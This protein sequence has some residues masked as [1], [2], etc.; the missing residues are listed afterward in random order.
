MTTI[1]VSRGHPVLLLKS[2]KIAHQAGYYLLNGR[3]HAV[4]EHKQPPA[5]APVVQNKPS[6]GE[7][8]MTA[9]MW[10]QLYEHADNSN[11]ATY[12]KKLDKLKEAYKA[13]DTKTILSGSYPNDTTG[14]KVAKIANYLLGLMGS[15]HTVHPGLKQGTH[16]ALSDPHPTPKP[17]AAPAPQAAEPKPAPT[18]E[19][20]A[21]PAPAAEPEPAKT[22][23]GTV[24]QAMWDELYSHPD[25]SNKSV[26]T[27]K[28]DKLKAAYEAGDVNAILGGSY[29]NDTTNKKVVK[30]ANFLLGEMGS[31]HQVAAGQKQGTHAALGASTPAPVG[32]PPQAVDAAKVDAAPEAAPEATGQQPDAMA[33]PTFVEGKT[34]TGVVAYYEGVAQQIIA[35]GAAGDVAG[36]T[37]MKEAGLTPSAKGKVSNTFKGKTANSKLLLQLHAASLQQAGAVKG[38]VSTPETAHDK[39][40]G[41]A[42]LTG[43]F[44]KKADVDAALNSGDSQ[45]LAQIVDESEGAPPDTNL[46]K[47]HAYAKQ[48][49][50]YLGGQHQGEDGPKDGDTKQGADGT[51]VFKNGRWHKMVA[52]DE[53]GEMPPTLVPVEDHPAKPDLSEKD[54]AAKISAY[55]LSGPEG[56]DHAEGQELFE[57]LT[58]E[59]QH[60]LTLAAIQHQASEAGKAN[61]VHPVDAVPVPDMS[62]KYDSHKSKVDAAL[63]KLKEQVKAEGASALKGVTKTMSASGK[64]ITKL[65]GQFGSFKV[66]GYEHSPDLSGSKVHAYVEALKAAVGPAKKAPKAKA[67]PATVAPQPP[68]HNAIPAMDDWKQVGGQAGSNPGGKF[69]DGD[70]VEWYC[71]FPGNDDVAKSEVLAAKLYQAAGIAGQDAMLVTKDGKL[72]IA[73]KW[74]DVKKAATPTALAKVDGVASGFAVDAWLGNWDVVGLE[75]DNLQVDAATGKAMRVDAGGS[76]EYRAQGGKK[77]F[78][79]SVLEID[80]LRD[81]KINPQSAKVFGKLTDADITASV[82]KVLKVSDAQIHAMVNTYGPGSAADKKKLA[83]T[84]IA[85]KADLLSKYPKAK[86]EKKPTFKPEN[87]SAPPSFMNWGGSGNDGP[88]SKKFLNEANEKAVQSIY[89]AAKTG[90]VDAVTGLSADTFNKNTGEVI[91]SAPV[92]EHPSQHVKGYAQQAINEINYQLNP[93]KRFRFDGGH[94][95]ASLNAAYPSHTGPHG[96]TVEKAGK[97]L[98]LGEPGTISLESLALPKVTHASGQLTKATYSPAAQAAVKAMPETQKQ[99]IKQYTGSSYQKMNTSLWTGN[100][101]GAAKAAGEALHTMGHDITAGTVLSRK[102][103]VSGEALD[104]I[105]KSTGKVLQEP[106]IMSTSIR[107]TSWS[108]NVQ[109]KLNVGPGVKGLWVGPGSAP[110]GGGLSVHAH[111]DEI[112]LPPN[113]RLLVLSVKKSTGADADGFGAGVQHVIEAVVLPTHQAH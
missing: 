51:L 66:I 9:E 96:A 26:F 94:P 19:P 12:T 25:N 71:K 65:P 33:M 40:Q 29:P 56:G 54:K 76:L 100:P 46:G 103:S 36:L 38:S 112:I 45:A 18:P 55:L 69:V 101:T 91:G 110:G 73:S 50:E 108:G 6:G 70:G 62:W 1:L 48:A 44:A 53:H 34:T 81:A 27:K 83:E 102:I 74:Q 84:L 11:K 97:F 92:L 77:S 86:K 5:G 87:I 89:E 95:L 42:D 59:K 20:K 47:V 106:A 75:Y 17:A 68:G 105:L 78:G 80:S 2:K 99:A 98:I 22:A 107:P 72:G 35:M 79:A 24:T 16:H 32:E 30:I 90:S 67:A 10:S 28:M 104:Q 58:P 111:E 52:T 88:S 13:G 14:K 23:Q 3:W 85:R 7:T 8:A 57:A 37:A 15:S 113:T 49:L 61:V 4:A 39:P 21:E 82:A 31:T 43:H 109:L 64:L 63:E 60:E 41:P 93:P